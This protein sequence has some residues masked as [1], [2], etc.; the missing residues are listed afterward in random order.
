MDVLLR[1]VRRPRRRRQP[2]PLPCHDASLPPPSAARPGLGPP[3]RRLRARRAGLRAALRAHGGAARRAARPAPLGRQVASHRALRRSRIRALP[4]RPHHPH[5]A[6]PEGSVCIGPQALEEGSRWGR[7]LDG[8]VDRVDQA[9]GAQSRPASGRISAPP[10]RGPRLPA[11]GDDARHLCLHRRAVRAADARDGGRLRLPGC[12]RQQLLRPPRG[13]HDL[14]LVDRALP[15]RPG[16]IRRRVHPGRCLAGDAAPWLRDR[17]GADAG[18]R[19]RSAIPL[20]AGRATGCAWP[21]G[22]PANGSTTASAARRT[23]TRW[24]RSRSRERRVARLHRRAAADRV[25]A[26]AG[27]A[28]PLAGGADVRGVAIPVGADAAR[29]HPAAGL[30][31]PI[32]AH[33]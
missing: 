25:D 14:D 16:A 1:P 10:L 3:P 15:R 2:R 31:R 27:D 8:G 13:R 17:A 18:R 29:P 23:P 26:H 4:Q 7:R 9:G 30:R 33:R 22:A 12:G 24:R 20:S 21:A 6:R 5:G 32:S 11:G 28:Q 19:A